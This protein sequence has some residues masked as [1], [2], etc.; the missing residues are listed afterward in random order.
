[1]AFQSKSQIPVISFPNTPVCISFTRAQYLFMDFFKEKIYTQWNAQILGVSFFEFWQIFHIPL[2]PKS[3]SKYRILSAHS[4][5]FALSPGNQCSGIFHNRWTLSF[6]ELYIN[7][8]LQYVVL[9]KASLTQP[10]AFEIH[11]CY[12]L[13][14]YCA[15]VFLY[16]DI[17]QFIFLLLMNTREVSSFCLRL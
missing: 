6:P 11:L 10:N 1:M 13:Y 17:P 8:S 9:C 14:L 4:S 5:P 7:G 3:S 12:N 2:Q 16:M 15:V